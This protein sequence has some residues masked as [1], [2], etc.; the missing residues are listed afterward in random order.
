MLRRVPV[1]AL[2]VALVCALGALAFPASAG[3][4]T[5]DAVDWLATQQEPDGGFEVADFPGFETLDAVLA[6]AANAQ[7]PEATSSAARARATS[8]TGTPAPVPTWST[9]KARSAVAAVTNG[10]KSALHYLDTYSSG[11]ICPGQ[12]AKLIVLTAVPLGFDPRSFDPAGDGS[13]VDLVA[14]ADGPGGGSCFAV[15]SDVLYRVLADAMSG[16]AVDQDD[17]DSIL[18]GQRPDGTWDF[19]GAA[20]S[21]TELDVDTTA[22]AL[23]ALIAAGLSPH[24]RAIEEALHALAVAQETTGGWPSPFAVDDPNSTAMAMAGLVAVGHNPAG[25]CWR[26]GSFQTPAD[27][28]SARQRSDGRVTS[29]NDDFS[30]N[31]FPT[32]QAVQGWLAFVLPFPKAPARRCLDSGYR[33]ASADGGV[34]AFGAP[35]HG[36]LGGVRLNQPIVGIASTP[37]GNGYW[38]VAADGGIFAFG[39]ARFFGSTGGIRLNRP[40]VGMAPTADGLGYWLVAADGG[41]FAFGSARFF[42]STGGIRL[43]QPVTG[44]AATPTGNGYWLVASDGGIFAFGDAG[45]LGSTGAIR[46]NQPVTGMAAHPSG[47][48]YWLL[49]RDGGV[50][51][52]G[53]ASFWGTLG[54]DA[55]A[56]V[57]SN[58][59]Q[60]YRMTSVD[61]VVEGRGNAAFSSFPCEPCGTVVGMAP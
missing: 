16:G 61:G 48:G 36:S 30:V 13:P 46:L 39:D 28:L 5:E 35:F 40:I 50:F 9:A 49:A 51:A 38:L 32:S 58:N 17:V 54:D 3:T 45:F 22:L 11:S 1:R 20:D 44:M 2:A 55:V 60:G 34:F 31:T 47:D 15:F 43:N 56:L 10:G 27:A 37:S 52:F 4:D 25:S 59:G 26:S 57:A 21:E 12:A 41:I 18:S 7:I 24:H 33:L 23:R 53:D 19:T 42:G 29:P 8:S 6:I 14:V